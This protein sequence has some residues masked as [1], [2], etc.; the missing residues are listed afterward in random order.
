MAGLLAGVAVIGAALIGGST[1]AMAAPASAQ[2][3]HPSISTSAQQVVFYND[4]WYWAY[5]DIWGY[6]SNNT[7]IYHDWSGSVGHSGRKPFTVPANVATLR[8]QVRME[9]FG[10]TIHSQTINPWYDFN[11]FC[12]D[13][14]HAT[15]YVG[16]TA[17]S[18]ND[19]D[20]HCSKW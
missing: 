8:W 12:T 5:A 10:N 15:I 20:L 14:K 4:G 7:E 2:A 13:G 3:V 18:T 16:G 6:D 17:G 9:P 11:N 19:Y 1:P